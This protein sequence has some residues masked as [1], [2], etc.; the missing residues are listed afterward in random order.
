M[1]F[2]LM[3]MSEIALA[4]GVLVEV[5][6]DVGNREHQEILDTSLEAHPLLGVGIL[7]EEGLKFPALHNDESIQQ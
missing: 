7:I 3:D 6:D 4:F 5:V 1:T 2:M